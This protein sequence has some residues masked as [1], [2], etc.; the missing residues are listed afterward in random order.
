MNYKK[1]KEMTETQKAQAII[2]SSYILYMVDG[3]MDQRGKSFGSTINLKQ[4][5]HTQTRKAQNLDY[6]KL[7]NQAWQMTVDKYKDKN[8]RIMIA[9]AVEGFYFNN[10]EVLDLMYGQELVNLVWRFTCKQFEGAEYEKE[11][12]PETNIITKD[13]T[14]SMRKV[15]FDH[16]QK[17]KG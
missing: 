2:V 6:I 13:L 5:L 12:I 7:S 4:K 17:L 1:E 10:Q 15:I 8:Y 14:E 16:L 3:L 11:V 9:H